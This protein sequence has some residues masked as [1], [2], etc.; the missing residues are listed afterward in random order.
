MATRTTVNE[1]ML[2]NKVAHT[3]QRPGTRSFD[4]ALVLV[5]LVPGTSVPVAVRLPL[6][7][8]VILLLAVAIWRVRKISRR[9][10]RARLAG[11]SVIAFV[12]FVLVHGT[13]KDLISA[14]ALAAISYLTALCVAGQGEEAAHR[15]I[16]LILM[17]GL[18][19][20]CIAGLQVA[21]G[22]PIIW[23]YLGDRSH[24]V[25]GVNSVWLTL[26]G[27]AVGTM[28]HPIA[29]G[30]LM[31]TCFLLALCV[32]TMSIRSRTILCVVFV[33]GLGV[34]GSRSAV[35]ATLVGL[36]LFFF[37]RLKGRFRALW[38]LLVVG[39]MAAFIGSYDFADSSFISSLNGSFSVSHRLG[40]LQSVPRL[41]TARPLF[42]VLFG[43]GYNSETHLYASNVLVFDGTQTALDDQ[44]VTALAWGGLLGLILFVALVWLLYYRASTALRPVVL[45]QVVMMLSFDVVSW[46]ANWLTLL[47]LS[48]LAYTAVTS[49]SPS[50]SLRRPAAP[51]AGI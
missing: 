10:G 32:R 25:I 41:F 21:F 8:V 50:Y 51:W 40:S 45:A 28:G 11:L 17:V 7:V 43:S 35:L 9:S 2:H 22:F 4:L 14:L 27:R 16:R 44:F 37:F 30:M 15:I 47:A 1:S 5:Y 12:P 31:A 46:S 49:R 13:W 29:L 34:A 48:S 26:D 39:V 38:R 42:E 23:G 36:S 19:E 18:G 33:L 24:A 20:L 6:Q 3:K